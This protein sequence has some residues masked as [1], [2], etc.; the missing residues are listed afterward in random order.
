MNFRRKK[1]KDGKLQSNLLMFLV[2]YVYINTNEGNKNSEDKEQRGERGRNC[3]LEC[4]HDKNEGNIHYWG[5][6]LSTISPPRQTRT[7][8][9]FIPFCG[10]LHLNIIAQYNL[11]CAQTQTLARSDEEQETILALIW[12]LTQTFATPIHI[13]ISILSCKRIQSPLLCVCEKWDYSHPHI[14]TPLLPYL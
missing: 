5:Y 11:M 14:L 2:Y 8:I 13:S 3:K 9:Q 1:Y 6:N 12:K 7:P 4:L 10:S